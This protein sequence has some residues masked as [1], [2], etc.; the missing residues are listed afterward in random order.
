ME[1]K[2]LMSFSLPFYQGEKC[3]FIYKYSFMTYHCFVMYSFKY[4][5]IFFYFWGTSFIIIFFYP[6]LHIYS[7]L[8]FMLYT[9]TLEFVGGRSQTSG[10]W[11][12]GNLLHRCVQIEMHLGT[13][14]PLML[15]FYYYYYYIFGPV[16]SWIWKMR[17]HTRF[18]WRASYLYCCFKG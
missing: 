7:V 4:F 3:L 15:T 14:W 11:R 6:F 1:E 13:V 8:S 9:I 17:A 2:N 5:F 10:M 16:Y 18:E 12:S